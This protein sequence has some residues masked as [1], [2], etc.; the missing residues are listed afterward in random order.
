MEKELKRLN[1]A[2][3]NSREVI[4]MTDKEGIITYI[5][6]EF[7]KTYGY[8]V[9]EIVGKVTPRILKSDTISPERVEQFWKG[10]L[11]KQSIN[12]EYKNKHKDGNLIE[13]EG[14]SDPILDY[15]GEIIG[16]LGIQRNITERKRAEEKIIFYNNLLTQMGNL[17][18]VGGWKIDVK[19]M[20]REWSDITYEIYDVDRNSYVP[21]LSLEISLF[22]E[23]D[24]PILRKAVED[25]I[26]YG[27]PYDLELEM[28]TVK[29]NHK[30]IHSIAYVELENG[31]PKSVYGAVWDITGQKK[32]EESVRISEEKYRSLVDNIPDYIMRYDRQHRHIFANSQT[33]RDTNMRPEDFLGKTHKEL[34]FAPH[35][36]RV[37]ENAIDKAFESGQPQAEMFEW[38][39]ALGVQKS[40]D[41]RVFP[42]YAND[43]SIESL[44]G[45]S[46]DIS[47]RKRADEEIKSILQTTMEGYFLVDMQGRILDTNDSY[48]RMIG[49]SR[50]ELLEMSIKDIDA[51]N[52]EESIKNILRNILDTGSD[53]FEV[54]HKHKDGREIFLEA[55]V[56][57]LTIGQPKVICF[58]HDITE[59]LYAEKARLESERLGAIGEMSAA[60]AHDF[61]N[62]LQ[63][64]VG[65]IE[66]SLLN[67]DN[68]Q[69]IDEYLNAAKRSAGDASAR[70]IQLQRFA[71]K[72]AAVEHTVLDLNK[73]FDEVI[74]QTRP[75][76]KNEAEKKGIKISIEKIYGKIKNIEGEEGE[77]RMVLHNIIKNAVEAMPNGGI[78]TLTSGMDGNDVFVRIGDTGMGMSE[79]IKRRIFQPF[80]TT[81]GFEAGR[82]LGMSGS[83]SIIRDHGGKISILES[84]VGKGTTI[85]LKFPATEMK[86]TESTKYKLILPL[87]ISARILWVDDDLDIREI[88]NDLLESLGHNV[89]MS[90]GGSEALS[91]LENNHYDLLI[92]DVAMP[93]MSG[94]QLTS[95]IKDT[96][97]NMKVAVISGWGAD[98]SE[99][100]KTMHGVDYVLGKPVTIDRLEKLVTDILKAKM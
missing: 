82:G 44:V 83:Y 84:I 86:A 33:F 47:E 72:A 53:F 27:K 19:T 45:I 14:S 17:A 88:G 81:K 11:N 2:I 78:I 23:K 28:V 31:K 5:N 29:G 21:N 61:N 40:F 57:L 71:S 15:S 93:D 55:S 34:G 6:P 85:E 43:G 99:E 36:C 96:Y 69:K 32:M 62:S 70:I 74:L 87:N 20:K 77:V 3:S 18:K 94:W 4:F 100:E 24:E 75:I 66:M 58:M 16:F 76:W 42:E 37:W 51:T 63:V 52:S 38:K 22:V 8:E 97:P 39:D 1:L 48:C 50:E 80:F 90:S 67:K 7:T 46:H 98:V 35:L 79:K 26:T 56:N 59:R 92:T 9:D 25:A 54:R 13:I 64:I 95:T 10:L 68:F 12:D 73:L 89:D 49:Y 91:L 41:W 30:I 60:I 65:N